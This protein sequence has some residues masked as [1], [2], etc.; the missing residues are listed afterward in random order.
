[1]IVLI[2]IS[3]INLKNNGGVNMALEVVVLDKENKLVFQ[4]IY[5]NCDKIN[6]HLLYKS[7]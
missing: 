6:R 7:I 3:L 5:N 4:G 1:M 2:R